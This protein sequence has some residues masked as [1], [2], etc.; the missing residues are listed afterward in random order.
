MSERDQFATLRDAVAWRDAVNVKHGLAAR[1]AHD[2]ANMSPD[3]RPEHYERCTTQT[4]VAVTADDDGTYLV[5]V[6]PAERVVVPASAVRVRLAYTDEART[7]TLVGVVL[8]EGR[9]R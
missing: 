2:L 4:L 6:H 3:I 1:R 8:D 7:K 5:D 9:T